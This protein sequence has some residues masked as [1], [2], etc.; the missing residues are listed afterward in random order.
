MKTYASIIVRFHRTLPVAIACLLFTMFMLSSTRA[1]AK[2]VYL[3]NLSNF[4]G[5]I[6]SSWVTFGTD[7]TQKELYVVNP[8]DQ[9]VDVFNKTGLLVYSFGE[10]GEFGAI[11][12]LDVDD[13]GTIYVLSSRGKRTQVVIANFRGDPQEV[14]KLENLPPL[15]TDNFN[16]ERIFC[17]KGHLY[18]I[19]P[20]EFKVLITDLHGNYEDGFEFASMIN[21][22]YKK[23]S[24]FDI[25][26]VTV[27]AEGT[28]IFTI[29]VNS[30]VYLISPDKK[31]TTFGRRGSSP[32]KFNIIGGVAADDKGRLYVADTLRCVIMVFERDKDFTFR[33]EY[34]ERGF[35]PGNLIAPMEV[36]VLGDLVYVSQSANRGVSV[37]RIT[38]E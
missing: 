3:Y 16:P 18:L 14:L 38:P 11:R 21:V 31:L 20:R 25:R 13:N 2:L 12:G 17:R 19:D 1:E 23:R 28:L 5:S 33:G 35:D 9:S 6:A 8:S 29:P 15:F 27:D 37:Y 7:K 4:N 34:G 30:L 22:N 36:A 24:D 32:G 26:G 10:E